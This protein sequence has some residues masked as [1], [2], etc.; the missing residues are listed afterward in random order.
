M[1]ITKLNGNVVHLTGL[2]WVHLKLLSDDTSLTVTFLCSSQQRGDMKMERPFPINHS[3]GQL[4]EVEAETRRRQWLP[5][6]SQRGS[7]MLLETSWLLISLSVLWSIR[8]WAWLYRTVFITYI[9]RYNCYCN[10]C[11]CYYIFFFYQL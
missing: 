8:R 9:S 5:F 4:R 7:V 3:R 10:Y 1:Y 6:F 11:Y 2:R